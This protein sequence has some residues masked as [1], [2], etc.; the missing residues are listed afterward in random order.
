M[1]IATTT[2]TPMGFGESTSNRMRIKDACAVV[3]AAAE[4]GARLLALPAGFLYVGDGTQ[5]RAGAEIVARARER[6]I[7]VVFGADTRGGSRSKR[8]NKQK[9]MNR[10]WPFFV[11]A[12]GTVGSYSIWRQRC[13]CRANGLDIDGEPERRA[14]E[15]DGETVDV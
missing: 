3:D 13:T 11:V 14:I 5:E 10:E 6:R 7:A 1:R 2:A 9:R 4:A 15:V 12:Q 8:A